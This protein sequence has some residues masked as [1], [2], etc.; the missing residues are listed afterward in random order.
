MP[1]SLL[2]T[3]TLSAVIKQNPTA[4]SHSLS[5][6]ATYG[7]L[8]FSLITRYEVLRGLK[9]KNALVQIAAFEK[10]CAVSEVLPLTDAVVQRAADIY[11]N[12]HQQGQ[13]IGE[14]DILIA[15]TATEN[16]L[17]CVTNNENHFKCIQTCFL[18]TGSSHD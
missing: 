15:A 13:L 7:M 3:D 4:V 2:D 5:Y 8:T 11:G 18:T 1:K 14:A 17:I 12:L 16:G 6:L 10:L 9:A